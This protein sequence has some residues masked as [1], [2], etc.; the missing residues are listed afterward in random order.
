M[1]ALA[2]TGIEQALLD[3]VEVIK[4]EQEL[5]VRAGRDRVEHAIRAGEALVQARG[6]VPYGRWGAFLARRLGGSWADRAAFYMRLAEHQDVVR[7]AGP[8]S[9]S[10][11]ARVLETTLPKTERQRRARRAQRKRERQHQA[12]LVL[13]RYE[14]ERVAK[15]V[16]RKQGGAIAEAYAMAERMQD[17]IA[18]AQREATDL[19]VRGD[20]ELAS[21]YHHSTR[22][23]IVRAALRL[24]SS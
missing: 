12:R 9:L 6:H 24:E 17:V 5:V 13:E 4:R 16:V 2:E 1:S 18:Q 21:G 10:Q 11:A 15:V 8:E 20:L 22:D 23:H 7:A 14:R 3:L 19:A